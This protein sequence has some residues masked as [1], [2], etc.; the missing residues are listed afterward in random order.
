MAL[1]GHHARRI[2][3]PLSGVKRTSR[4]H[5]KLS[6]SDPKRT[7]AARS[8]SQNKQG[9]RATLHHSQKS[10]EQ[11]H[12]CSILRI[13]W[14][15]MG[16]MD[17]RRGSGRRAEGFHPSANQRQPCGLRQ[18]DQSECRVPCGDLS[19][20]RAVSF[21]SLPKRVCVYG[22]Q[23]DRSG[24]IFLHEATSQICH[25]CTG[26]NCEHAVPLFDMNLLSGVTAKP[27]HL[28]NIYSRTAFSILFHK[29]VTWKRGGSHQPRG[30]TR[31]VRS[32]L[33]CVAAN[34]RS[35]RR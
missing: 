26:P 16:P 32:L 25:R 20:H 8:Y 19:H 2:G 10:H 12:G 4:L 29:N 3:C 1:S 15:A 18:A 33:L 13:I 21:S 22:D 17:H 6:A 30:I 27:R 7:L 31:A 35:V 23:T 28:A 5:R 14:T 9:M 11:C 34:G 24:Y